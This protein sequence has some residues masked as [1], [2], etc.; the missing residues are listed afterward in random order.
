M[1]R[2]DDDANEHGRE[3]RGRSATCYDPLLHLVKTFLR[4]NV[5]AVNLLRGANAGTVDRGQIILCNS[6]NYQGYPLSLSLLFQKI[7][8]HPVVP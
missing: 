2:N 6:S 4:I 7:S 8:Y 3:H 1:K 5:I